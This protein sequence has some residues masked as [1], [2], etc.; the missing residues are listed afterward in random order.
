MLEF[1]HEQG[2]K[3]RKQLL[4][5]TEYENTIP[6]AVVQAGKQNENAPPVEEHKTTASVDELMS[7]WGSAIHKQLLQ[8]MD[9]RRNDVNG[10]SDEQLRS[11]SDWLIKDII[12]SLATQIPES[13]DKQRL[14]ENVLNES[15]GYGPLE[16]YLA[17]STVS[18]IMVNNCREIYIECHGLLQRADC[19][20]SSNS[21]VLSVIDRIITPL[22]KRIDESSPIIDARLADGSRVNAVIPPLTLKGPCL[23]IRKF[24]E[25]QLDFPDLIRHGALSEVMVEFLR[26]CVQS[27][28]NIVVVGGTGSG[29][30]TLLNVLSRFIPEAERIVTIED[31]AELKL[32][33]PNIV[34][35]ESRAANLDGNN[36][37][38]IRD[39]VRNAL[40]MRPDRIV[41]GECR[42]GEAL[43]MLQAMNT[44][45][46]GSLTTL[47]ANSPR[48]ALSRLEVMV[49][50]AG[51]D[52]PV[53]AIRE[54][55]SSAVDIIVQMKRF[56]SGERKLTQITE[57][58]GMESGTIQCQDLFRFSSSGYRVS[59][60]GR[61]EIVGNFNATGAIPGFFEQLR[62]SGEDID[63][64]LFE[65]VDPDSLFADAAP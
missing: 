8:Q 45:H 38:P 21:A 33:Q 37:I 14:R 62:E 55:V 27:Q 32:L 5:D 30:T 25:H 50:M 15:V 47:H 28:R 54:Q 16:P 17:D 44:G 49:L 7:H 57:V 10:M 43:D 35:M 59:Q 53:S 13:I 65:P 36:E 46:D 51:I 58:V 40:R 24:P 63:L 64:S 4:S 41:V 60:Q 42:G 34:S 52:I 20:F 3:Q 29:K 61:K 1:Y 23:T 18:E 48:D 26:V 2:R 22:G 6:G 11:E 56:A 31:A 19:R 12:D 9:L 39:L